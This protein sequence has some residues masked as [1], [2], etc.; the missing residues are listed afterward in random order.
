[1]FS[2]PSAAWNAADG[3]AVK[4][5]LP[6]GTGCTPEISQFDTTHPIVASTDSSIETSMKHPRFP[7]SAAEIAKAAVNPPMV[8]AMG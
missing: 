8:S 1:M 3:E 5:S 6:S 4:F 2:N 7:F